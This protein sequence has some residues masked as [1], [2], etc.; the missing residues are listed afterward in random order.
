VEQ[1]EEFPRGGEHSGDQFYPYKEVVISA[2]NQVVAQR[3]ANTIH[4]AHNL[5]HGFN[6]FGTFSSGP[7]PVSPVASDDNSGPSAHRPEFHASPDIPLAC[8][9]AA[10]VSQ[11]RRFGY[12]LA[13]LQISMEVM[14]FPTIELDPSHSPNIP[15]SLFAEDHIRMAVAITAAYAA[16]EEL[17]LEIRASPQKPSR[18]DGRWNPEVRAELEQRLTRAGVDLSEEFHWNLRGKRTRIEIRRSREITKLAPWA[19]SEVRDGQSTFQTPLLTRALLRSQIAAHGREDKHPFLKVLSVYDATNTQF[20]AR[21]LF[22]ESVGYWRY[23]QTDE[24]HRKLERKREKHS[25]TSQMGDATK[26]PT[27]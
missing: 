20:L 15:K 17:H 7:Q 3:A 19:R 27:M 6:L 16:I 24:G 11:R 13:R 25:N 23:L 2:R 12:A 8:L 26:L 1:S 22:L 10:R 9:I 21:R 5:L 4:N 18:I 14:S